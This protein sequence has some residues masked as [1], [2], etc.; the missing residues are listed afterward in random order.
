MGR[1]P[2]QGVGNALEVGGGSGR[3]LLQLA[4]M[5]WSVQGLEPSLATAETLRPQIELPV[6]TRTIDS[7]DFDPSTFDLIVAT[8]VLEHLHD[9]FADARRL[10]TWLRS[11]GHLMGSVPNCASWECRF[12]GRDGY[13]LQVPTH[14]SH[15]TPKTLT[16]LLEHTGFYDIRIFHQSNVNNLMIHTG[17]FFAR[18][19]LPFAEAL[20]AFP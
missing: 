16:N 6:Q 10:H 14:L 5:D 11:G 1:S 18:H 8:I 9:P 13:A 12:F 17:R 4:D 2:L 20:L 3:F 19:E 7:A 15:F